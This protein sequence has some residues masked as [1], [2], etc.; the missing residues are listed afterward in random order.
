MYNMGR[1]IWAAYGG[2]KP[3]HLANTG[4]RKLALTAGNTGYGELGFM[5]MGTT[6]R[7]FEV[8]LYPPLSSNLEPKRTWSIFLLYDSLSLQVGPTGTL[9]LFGRHLVSSRSPIPHSNP[10]SL[11]CLHNSTLYI[12]VR[13][14]GMEMFVDGGFFNV[15]ERVEACLVGNTVEHSVRGKGIEHA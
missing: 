9:A 4:A 8:L 12:L 5:T 6:W 13:S 2:H 11:F 1:C 7:G 3:N 14:C 10:N 15:A